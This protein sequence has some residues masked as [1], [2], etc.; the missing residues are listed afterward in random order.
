M[1]GWKLLHHGA[2]RET[3]TSPK[4]PQNTPR[5]PR[6]RRYSSRISEWLLA[7]I[8]GSAATAFLTRCRSTEVIASCWRL[9]VHTRSAIILGHARA[10][11]ARSHP[12]TVARRSTTAAG[13]PLRPS[14]QV[15][16]NSI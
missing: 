4:E 2:S 9:A 14:F 5:S 6:S 8:A 12:E 10:A 11:F 13:A 3:H 1:R 16:F 15:G 7:V